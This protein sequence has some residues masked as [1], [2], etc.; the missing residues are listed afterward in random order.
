M[1]ETIFSSQILLAYFVYTFWLKNAH[2]KKPFAHQ[3][4]SV[5]KKLQTKRNFFALGLD[6]F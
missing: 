5:L 4:T 1:Q 6:T 3:W 2:S